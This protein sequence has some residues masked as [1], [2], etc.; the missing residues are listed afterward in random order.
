MAIRYLKIM[1]VIFVSL[2]CLMYAAQNVANLDAAYTF[3]ASAAGMQDHA[4]Y[5]SSFG[6]SVSSP[7]LVWTALAVIIVGEFA[8]GLLAAKGAWDLWAARRA[9][10][11]GFNAAKTCA[12]LGCGGGMVVWFGLFGAIGGAYFQMWQTPLG[13]ASLEGAFQ[14]AAQIGIVMLFVNMSDD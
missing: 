8:A 11:A 9:P 5:P 14:F 13:S 10:A 1:L 2:L 3:V 4:A 12:L 7:A 6:P